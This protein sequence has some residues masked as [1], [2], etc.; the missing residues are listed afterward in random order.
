MI[1]VAVVAGVLFYPVYYYKLA[2]DSYYLAGFIFV[3]GLLFLLK[4]SRSNEASLALRLA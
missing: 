2:P 3:E 1:V 4:R